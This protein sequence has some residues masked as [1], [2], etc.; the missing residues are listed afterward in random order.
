MEDVAE[1]VGKALETNAVNETCN[2]GT[3]VPIKIKELAQLVIEASRREGVT[4]QHGLQTELSISIEIRL[5]KC[6]YLSKK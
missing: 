2:I 4:P 1:A 5:P 6:E 3:G